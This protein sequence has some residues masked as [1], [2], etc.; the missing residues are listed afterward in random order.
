MDNPEYELDLRLVD[1]GTVAG[2]YATNTDDDC[3]SGD[4]GTSACTT[5]AD[6]S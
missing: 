1:A 3:G 5:S 2:G 4:T 6:G